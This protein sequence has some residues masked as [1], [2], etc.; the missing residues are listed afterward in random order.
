MTEEKKDRLRR[1][2]VARPEFTWFTYQDNVENRGRASEATFV[3]L[4]FLHQDNVLQNLA[5]VSD[6]DLY[7]KETRGRERR[8]GALKPV[9]TSEDYHRKARLLELGEG[10]DGEYSMCRLTSDY[11]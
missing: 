6:L 9:M 7:P 11:V 10:V 1:D 8:N 4:R 5:N 3:G 2:I